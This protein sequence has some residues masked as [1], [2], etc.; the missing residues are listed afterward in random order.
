MDAAGRPAVL[1]AWIE[2]QSCGRIE[3]PAHEFNYPEDMA[4]DAS[5][6]VWMPFERCGRQAKLH[7]RR[8]IKPTH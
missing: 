4:E 2:C 3:K 7:I 6:F 5:P 8:E 1:V